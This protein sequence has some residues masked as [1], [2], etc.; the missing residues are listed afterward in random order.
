MLKN[1]LSVSGKPGLYRKIGENARAIIVESLQDG[2]R[3]IVHANART[4]P[5]A[6]IALYAT[7]QDVPLKTVF[8]RVFERENGGATI[9]RDETDARVAEYMSEIVPEYDRQKVY[10]SDMKKVLQWYN[11]LQEKGLLHFEE[12]EE[13]RATKDQQEKAAD[14]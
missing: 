4:N 3:T 9:A 11:I 1:I 10:L 2:K 12:E 7:P 5:L 13:E 8:K 6:D 14:E